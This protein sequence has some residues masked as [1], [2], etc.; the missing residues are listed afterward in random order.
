MRT[1][2]SYLAEITTKVSYHPHDLRVK[3]QG[4]INLKSALHLV[5]RTPLSFFLPRVFIFVKMIAYGV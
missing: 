1:P 3:G 4:H 5:T 2:P